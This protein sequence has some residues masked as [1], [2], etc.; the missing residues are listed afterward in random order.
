M[1]VQDFPITTS[2]GWVKG[3]PLHLDPV[4]HPGYGF[5]QGIDY[6][7]PSGTPVIINGVTIGLSGSTGYSSGPHCH[8]GKWSGGQVLDPGVGNGFSFQS[9]IV[10]QVDEDN[11]DGKFVRVQGDGFSWVYCH[12]SD[13]SKVKVGQILKGEEVADIIDENLSKIL[14]HGILA[15]NGVAGRTYSLD[16]STGTPW[17]GTELTAKFI[18]D[19]FNSTE[20]QEW[21]DSD[22]A[23]SVKG[24]NKR[25]IGAPPSNFKKVLT[26]GTDLY[27]EV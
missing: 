21:R 14:Q 27:T 9:A 16:G 10:T 23:D 15:R 26:A 3:Y 11:S 20:A 18:N 7:C 12:L 5:H 13:N 22:N 1:N 25:L 17:V 4:N 24:I 6:G 19:I 2:Y 8:V